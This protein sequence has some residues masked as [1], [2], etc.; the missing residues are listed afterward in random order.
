MYRPPYIHSRRVCVCVCVLYFISPRIFRDYLP[1]A[2]TIKG[3]KE[4]MCVSVC[5]NN[6]KKK[7]KNETERE[8]ERE[9]KTWK[10]LRE[11]YRWLSW[12]STALLW[13]P[14]RNVSQWEP[15]GYSSLLVLERGRQA[16]AKRKETGNQK[17]KLGRKK[18]IS[19]C[20]QKRFSFS[21]RLF[22]FSWSQQT[23][24]FIQTLQIKFVST[25][26]YFRI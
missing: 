11:T 18:K 21:S 7:E 3:W 17:Y 2:H 4:P 9:E 20:A 6:N 25:L 10:Y 26:Y 1:R 15:A 16:A 19:K 24:N 13:I 14:F 22:F 23:T 12:S 5:N 8:R